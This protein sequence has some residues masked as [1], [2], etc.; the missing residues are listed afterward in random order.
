MFL[1][2]RCAHLALALI[3]GVFAVAPHQHEGL[4]DHAASEIV[5]NLGTC[6]APE[7]SHIHASREIVTPRCVACVRHFSAGALHPL[8]AT[9]APLVQPAR[10]VARLELAVAATVVFTPLR[11]PP[12]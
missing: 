6:D 7:R 3:L 4:S 2:R 8:T 10:F 1:A 5:T 9:A 11:A 12:V